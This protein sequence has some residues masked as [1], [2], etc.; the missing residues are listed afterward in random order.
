MA[1]SLRTLKGSG[2]PFKSRLLTRSVRSPLQLVVQDY[3]LK[4]TPLLREL[5]FDLAHHPQQTRVVPDLTR[6]HQPL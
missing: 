4:A 5:G 6:L 1:R 2:S 3:A